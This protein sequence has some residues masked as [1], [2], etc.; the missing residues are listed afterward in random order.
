MCHSIREEHGE[1]DTRRGLFVALSAAPHF[2]WGSLL[3]L[4]FFPSNSLW[5][6]H[7]CGIFPVASSPDCG[8]PVASPPSHRYGRG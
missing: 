5:G 2:A 4:N 1:T 8:L 6:H 3:K 7:A